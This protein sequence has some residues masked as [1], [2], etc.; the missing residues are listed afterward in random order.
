MPE[1]IDNISVFHTIF[2]ECSEA[3]VI[4]DKNNQIILVNKAFT[5]ITGYTLTEVIGKKPSI[6]SSGIHK[7]DFYEDMWRSIV[8]TGSWTGKI[9]NK[10]K[11]N[12]IYPEHL[13]VKALT[14]SDGEITNHIGMFSDI[15]QYLR[16]EQY[17]DFLKHY[18]Q[19]TELPNRS[20]FI[21]IF[22]AELAKGQPLA[23]LFFDINRFRNIN[24]SFGYAFGDKVL[25]EFAK[26]LKTVL[27]SIPSF[28]GRHGS[29]EFIIACINPK[30]RLQVAKL[31]NT[32]FDLIKTPLIIN[33]HHI[34][35][36]G[37]I[38]ISCYPEDGDNM[39]TLLKHANTAMSLAKLEQRDSFKF[40]SSKMTNSIKHMVDLEE[41]LH[42]ALDNDEFEIYL[43]PKTLMNGTTIVGVEAL[44]RWH[45]GDKIVTPVEFLHLAE[46]I[47]LINL[48]GNWVTETVISVMREFEK[49]NLPKSFSYSINLSAEQFKR[50][51]DILSFEDFTKRINLNSSMS[52]TLDIEITESMIMLDPEYSIELIN[53]LKS[54][55]ITISIDD[56]GTGYSSLAYLKHLPIDTLKIDQSFIRNLPMDEDD[57]AI[58]K[59]IIALAKN[60][61]IAVIAEGVETED[62][63]KFLEE[64]GCDMFQGYF[65][66]KP[67]SIKDFEE[68]FLKSGTFAFKAE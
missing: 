33:S 39:D 64:N 62:Q 14:N 27:S 20:K 2:N 23:L 46:E 53:I 43:Q 57:A 28:I 66:S 13:T 40:Y 65:V 36:S 22:D 15:G 35:L 49:Y 67:I 68:I 16:S 6:L 4:T 21:S 48:I 56:F 31:A 11:N 26:K 7:K 52:G 12:D 44:I 34:N 37:A 55:G 9:W 10:R 32:I 8:E 59:A 5:N 19:L 17:V 42:K 25:A 58:A 45:Q 1:S 18:D 30:N 24:N 61:K 60:L 54:N 41:A 3:I 63:R 47:G 51:G 50:S 38:G 29:D